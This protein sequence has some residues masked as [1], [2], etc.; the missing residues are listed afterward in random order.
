MKKLFYNI[1]NYININSNSNKY[2]CIYWDDQHL[3]ELI[4]EILK[5]KYWKT[6]IEN[7]YIIKRS[8]HTNLTLSCFLSQEIYKQLNISKFIFD[9]IIDNDDLKKIFK[10]Y[11]MPRFD[12]IVQNPPYGSKSPEHLKFLEKG[13]DLLNDNGKMVIIEPSIHLIN[14]RHNKTFDNIKNKLNNITEKIIIDNYKDEF[15]VNQRSLYAITYINKSKLSNNIIFKC[16]GESYK[17]VNNIY[18]CNLIGS[19]NLLWSILKK[20]QSFNNM[21]RSH[22]VNHNKPNYNKNDYFLRFATMMPAHGYYS[23]VDYIKHPFGQYYGSY[24][25]SVTHKD[26]YLPVKTIGIKSTSKNNPW[27]CTFGAK[28]ELINLSYNNLNTKLFCFIQCVMAI[29]TKGNCYDYIPWLVD[30]KYTDE[31]IYEKFGFT[32]D[33]IKLI[34]TTIKKYER[35]SPWFK[36]YMCGPSSVSDEEVQKFI[37]GLNNA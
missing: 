3:I 6:H 2:L 25:T 36:R 35:Y 21:F 20:I 29:N 27:D 24:S 17:I 8:I 12:Y 33:E 14:I 15:N 18:D 10:K 30:K 1:C 9:D 31:E 34:E 23:E 4:N 5:I 37:D 22:V 19:Y 16:C 7:I 32:E 26:D 11:G 13:I 28:E